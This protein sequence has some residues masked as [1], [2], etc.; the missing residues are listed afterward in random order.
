MFGTVPVYAWYRY[1]CRTELTKVSGTGIDVVPNLPKCPVPVLMYRNYW[2]VRYR[3]YGCRTELT[4]VSGTGILMSYR[5]YRSG[6]YRY[7]FCTELTGVSATGLQVCTG[8]VGTGI[9]IVPNLPSCPI[10]VSISYRTYQSVWYRY[11]C[12][13]ELTEVSGTSNTGGMP[14]Y[15]PHRT[16]PWNSS[17]IC[18]SIWY[19]H[20]S[21]RLLFKY[22]VRICKGTLR[23]LVYRPVWYHLPKRRLRRAK[24]IE[25]RRKR[26]EKKVQDTIDTIHPKK[27]S[28]TKARVIFT[29]YRKIIFQNESYTN[30]SVERTHPQLQI[31][32]AAWTTASYFFNSSVPPV[33]RRDTWHI[34]RGHIILPFTSV[35]LNVGNLEFV[36]LD[37]IL[38]E[39]VFG[40]G[41][42]YMRAGEKSQWVCTCVASLTKPKRKFTW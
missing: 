11:W 10:P 35:R 4:E 38:T 26:N 8:T 23:A 22:F 42:R 34:I 13:T 3:W 37:G 5:T 21:T 1:G 32:N 39:G 27:S 29:S 20:R 12:R 2:S 40:W 24:R 28:N 25:T 18:Y 36:E 9:H 33:Y 14:R 41:I 19:V 31:R 15:V 17:S 16:H 30:V 6:R 7:W